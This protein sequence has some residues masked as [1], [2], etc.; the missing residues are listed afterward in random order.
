MPEICMQKCCTKCKN[1]VLKKYNNKEFFEIFNS[2]HFTMNYK[3]YDK[4]EQGQWEGKAD[5]IP[6]L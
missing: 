1:N 2:D 3:S 4:V 5:R 6:V